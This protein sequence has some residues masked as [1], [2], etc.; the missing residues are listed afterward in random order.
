MERKENFMLFSDHNGSLL[1]QQ[2]RATDA[3]SARLFM[4]MEWLERV[5][6]LGH[7]RNKIT[8][9]RNMPC[10]GLIAQWGCCADW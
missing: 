1:R 7:A 3:M 10:A 9:G 4:C 6:T 8:E 2:P 5:T